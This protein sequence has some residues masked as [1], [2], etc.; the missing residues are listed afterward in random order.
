MRA[1]NASDEEAVR[2]HDL[3]KDWA[4]EGFLTKAQYEQM[5]PETACALRRT[6]VFLR[7]VLFLFTV[8]IVVAAVA[9][10]FSSGPTSDAVV[11]L[12]FAAVAYAGAELAISQMQLYRF[13]IEEALASCSVGL[14]P[15]PR[16][17]SFPVSSC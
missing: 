14:T 8:L 10:F 16:S 11:L 2:A 17:S 1:Y 6:N 12:I 9:L 13:G 5:E 4:G 7:I 3:L 15:S